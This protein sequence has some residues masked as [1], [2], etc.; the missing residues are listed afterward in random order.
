MATDPAVS[1]YVS[2]ALGETLAR[3]IVF[4]ASAAGAL[5]VIGLGGL[6]RHLS[7]TKAHAAS[8]GE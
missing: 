2:T 3:Q 5:L 4:P 6:W 1:G 8:A 7:T